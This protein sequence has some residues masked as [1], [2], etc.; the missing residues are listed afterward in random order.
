VTLP[1]PHRRST[2]AQRRQQRAEFQAIKAQVAGSQT[3]EK[4]RVKARGDDNRAR[5]Q[6]K[7]KA[8]LAGQPIRPFSALEAAKIRPAEHML[9]KAEMNR[10]L[11]GLSVGQRKALNENRHLI[12]VCFDADQLRAVCAGGNT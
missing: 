6:K 2:A 10:R 5:A 4:R 1:L 8:A 12:L 3:A 7:I 9:L 11:G